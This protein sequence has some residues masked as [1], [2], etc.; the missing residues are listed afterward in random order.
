[1]SQISKNTVYYGL[2]A[3]SSIGLGI[4]LFLGGAFL[5]IAASNVMPF[6]LV[7]SIGAMLI[8]GGSFIAYLINENKL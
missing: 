5:G 7:S 6:L 1:M 3:W 8:G 2:G 4:V